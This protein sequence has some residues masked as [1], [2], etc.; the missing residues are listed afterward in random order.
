[1]SDRVFAPQPKSP[2]R[3]KERVRLRAKSTTT[4]QRDARYTIERAAFLVEHP[5]CEAHWDEGC[6]FAA[7]EVH[8]QG[9]RAASV[10]FRKSWWLAACSSCHGH[11]TDNPAEAFERGLSFHRNGVDS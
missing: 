10:F 2:P 8:H 1:M 9:G 7:T 3:V 4:A 6:T 5:I 11:I